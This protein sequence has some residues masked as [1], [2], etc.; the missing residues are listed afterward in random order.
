MVR[1]LSC[2]DAEM[3]AGPMPLGCEYIFDLGLGLF[4]SM[5]K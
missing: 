4:I 5:E 3:S 1:T 2:I